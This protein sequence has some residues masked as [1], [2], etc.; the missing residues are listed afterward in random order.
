MEAK[1]QLRRVPALV[2]TKKQRGYTAPFVLGVL[3]MKIITVD[4]AYT[5]Y[6]RG[7]DNRVSNNI[8]HT[9]VRSYIGVLFS[10]NYLKYFAPL[11]SSG[12]G[13]KLKDSPKAE[14]IT[15]YPI[16]EC[17]LGGVNFNNMIPIID[18]VYHL[19]DIDHEPDAKKKALLQK[20]AIELRKNSDH[21][22]SKA[23]KLYRLKTS[24]LLYSN[25]DAVTCDF[26]LLEEKAKLYT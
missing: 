15:F 2:E 24:G 25:Y 12:K 22:I 8:N 19:I 5:D 7:F 20:Q 23:K 6:L 17:R 11:T 1:K 26:K 3:P 21:L 16:D 14:S 10:V 13:R 4:Q 9:Y 18:G